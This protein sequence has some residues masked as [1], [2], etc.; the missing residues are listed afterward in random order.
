MCF[1]PT[2]SFVTAGITG[3]LGIFSLTRV[4]EPRQI[5]LAATPMI[6]A[7][8]Q[9]IEG[10]LWLNLP[11]APVGVLSASLTS[12]FLFFATVFWPVF[13]PTAVWLI[14]PD[15]KRRSLMLLCLAVGLGVGL[16]CFWTILARSHGANILDGHIVYTT[17]Y[18]PFAPVDY[19][20]LIA[21]GLPL[22]LSSHRTVVILGAIIIAGSIA[23]YA[24][25]WEAFA[26]VWCFFAATA[27]VV[28]LCH[29][30]VSRRQSL[31]MARAL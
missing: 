28:I 23:A 6:F 27:S 19:G 21:T 16:Y 30:E 31:R 5:P 4:N 17:A 13:S 7:L 9:T 11:V 24:F 20:Y 1:S 25:Y 14:E 22:I 26:S 18:R 12:L 2:A 10:L 8:Q 3:A 29:F 15:A